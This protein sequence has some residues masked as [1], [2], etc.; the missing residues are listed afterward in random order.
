M[1]SRLREESMLAGRGAGPLRVGEE[2]R[3]DGREDGA[4]GVEKP[5]GIQ[6]EGMLLYL[7][8]RAKMEEGRSA[9][10]GP[11][12]SATGVWAKGSR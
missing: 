12:L 8:F 7:R 2:A 9:A 3:E 4:E 1:P 11:C 5:L 6:R 10:V